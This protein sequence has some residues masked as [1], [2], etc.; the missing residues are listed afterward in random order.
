MA[1][2]MVEGLKMEAA[3]NSDLSN[4]EWLSMFERLDDGQQV[5]YVCFF[6]TFSDD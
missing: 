3:L 1:E 6:E 5:M 4:S 2:A